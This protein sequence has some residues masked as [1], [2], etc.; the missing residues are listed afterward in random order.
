MSW[1][2]ALY[3]LSE[4]TGID[5]I[6]ALTASGLLGILQALRMQSYSLRAEYCQQLKDKR[7]KVLLY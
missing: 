6:K 1:D 2:D 5:E 3:N 7:A 4:R